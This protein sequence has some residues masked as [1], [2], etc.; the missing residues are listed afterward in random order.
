[1]IGFD[2]KLPTFFV[3]KSSAS[4]R[5]GRIGIGNMTDPQAKLHILGD[6]DPAN[7]DDASLFI[8]SSGNYYSTIWLGDTDHSIETKPSSDLT[9]KTPTNT[10]FVF[11]NGEVGIGSPPGLWM[12]MGHCA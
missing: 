6:N 4:N 1:M 10:D 2:S 7:T 5:T 12:L 11:E 8:Q 3:G 9:F